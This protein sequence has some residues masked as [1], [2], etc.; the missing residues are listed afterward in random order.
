MKK[1]FTNP[2]TR[3]IL[4]R[5]LRYALAILSFYPLLRVLLSDTA[6]VQ[7]ALAE[8]NV[9]LLFGSLLLFMLILPVMA[10]PSWF[11]VRGFGAALPLKRAFAIYF[12]TQLPKYLPGGFWA[13][14]SRMLAYQAAGLRK[15][16]SVISVLREVGV[17]FLGAVAVGA[18][19][20]FQGPALEPV[21]QAA[22]GI[23]VLG[24]ILFMVA[25]QFRVFWQVAAR[26]PLLRNSPLAAIAAEPGASIFGAGWLLPALC[27]SLVFWL[28]MGLPFRQLAVAVSPAFQAMS[29]L[30]ASSLFALSWSAGFVMVLV[31]AGLGVRE[32][33]V[34]LLL[35]RLGTEGAAVSVALLSRLAWMMVE[36]MCI[37]LSLWLIGGP[38]AWSGVTPN[39]RD[40]K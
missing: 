32:S 8:T 9:P 12:L 28:L 35:A 5:F 26:L 13:F 10:F 7:S 39:A 38:A 27:S 17:L 11:S 16:Q 37:A 29:W 40:Q 20:L 3:T 36:G 24:T 22:I 4:T 18:L 6:A 30:E 23:G 25:M 31:P 14:P 19:S 33:V 21:L 15:S 1:L 34:A 2:R